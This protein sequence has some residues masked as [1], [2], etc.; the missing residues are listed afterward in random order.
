MTAAFLLAASAFVAACGGATATTTPGAPTPSP[1]PAGATPAATPAEGETPAASVGALP[2]FDL[3]ALSGT[4]PVDSYKAT[5][6]VDGV[7]QYKTTVVTKPELS[8]D[9]TTMQDGVPS[10][11]FVV[12]GKEA[13][14]QNGPNE[15]FT[16]VPE[17]LA[18]SMLLAF[19]P[20]TLLAAYQGLDLSHSAADQGSE[21]KNGVQ[22]RHLHID[23]S[24][25]AG[26]AIAIPAG[27][28]IDL[29][30]A[31]AGYIVGWEM[32]G[33]G[34]GQSVSIQITDIDDPSNKVERPS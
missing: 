3:S 33:F 6:S 31:D 5:L 32:T 2:S 29:W 8:K 13:W 4:L 14:S 25:F 28:A 7:E 12:I 9:I 27:A 23:P 21:Q 22:A 15:K 17:Q 34:P 11:R 16:E 20:S 19:D 10:T 24:T 26:G 30:V 1:A 18:S